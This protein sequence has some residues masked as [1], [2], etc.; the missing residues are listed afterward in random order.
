MIEV[1]WYKS[2][3][4]TWLMLDRVDLANETDF[5]V[6]II[7]HAGQPPR[8]VRVGQGDIASRLSSH[9]NDA[10][11][12]SYGR[13]ATL[14]VTWAVVSPRLVDGV[15]RYLAEYWKPLV[16]DRFPYAAPIAVNSPF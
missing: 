7:W 12:A 9:R 11:V 6:Y 8:V 14:Y 4:G 13:N 16:G 1:H 15:E 10:R 5:G 2:K 3:A